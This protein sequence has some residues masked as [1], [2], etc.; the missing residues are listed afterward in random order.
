MLARIGHNVPQEAP[1]ETVA[2]IRDLMIRTK[3]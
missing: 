1:S 3:P 2:A